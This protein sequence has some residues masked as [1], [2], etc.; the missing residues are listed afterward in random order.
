MSETIQKTEQL[1]NELSMQEV[2]QKML[3]Q[4]QHQDD[5]YSQDAE[6]EEGEVEPDHH[7]HRSEGRR[8]RR[9]SKD[10]SRS[11]SRD[12]RKR[13]KSRSRSRERKRSRSREW[14]SK[15]RDEGSENRNEKRRKEKERKALGFPTHVKEK[16]MTVCSTTIW[17]G[18]LSKN[19]TQDNIMDEM[20]N[21]GEVHSVN[22]VPPRGCAYVCLSSRKDASR[23]LSKLK[24]VKLLG[25]TLKV[26]SYY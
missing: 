5:D 21:Y 15:S 8:R 4:Q 19:T 10:R 23:A 7:E 22:L 9:R 13:R 17:I 20:V 2:R 6:M 18:H 3:E 26:S 25:N 24:G 1:K 11:H 14:R 16:H 12:R